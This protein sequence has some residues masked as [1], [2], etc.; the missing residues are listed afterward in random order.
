MKQ[1]AAVQGSVSDHGRFP[2]APAGWRP[3]DAESRA[4]KEGLTLLPD[5]YELIGA[6][7]EFFGRHE[8]RDINKRELHDALEERFHSRGG[9]RYLYRLCPGGP[10]AQ[11]CRL[12]GLEM[13]AGAVDRSF[14]SVQ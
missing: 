8:R 6:L 2:F 7:Q 13:P 12:A 9:R 3:N 1:S 10:V 11:G 5:H 14:G 4:G